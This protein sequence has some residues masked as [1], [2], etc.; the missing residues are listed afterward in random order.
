MAGFICAWIS[1]LA[2]WG[3]AA[4]PARAQDAHGYFE[5]ANTLGIFAAYSDDSS[6]ILM[7]AA[8]RR[9]LLDIG[10]VYDRRIRVGHVVNWQYSAEILPVALESDPLSGLIVRQTSPTAITRVYKL[11]D[12][13]V[14]CAVTTLSY[15]YKDPGTGLTYTGTDT[16][17]CRSR[18]WTV[19]EA[20]SPVGFQWNFRPR[21][22][23]Q[24]FLVGHGG[25]MYSSKPIPT[26]NAGAFNFTFDFGAGLEWY[27][28]ASRSWRIEY[29]YH[30][31]S[32]HGTADENPGIDNGLLQLTYAFGR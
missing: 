7:G 15:N 14:S 8:E 9:K 18:Q 11:D 30:H 2:A 27:K 24:P 23:L 16:Y 26:T 31:I 3:L 22:Q 29:R 17:Y 12:P 6:H 1:G 21:H 28:A 32:N 25:Y 19:G 20:I 4:Q 13:L 5:R 10:I